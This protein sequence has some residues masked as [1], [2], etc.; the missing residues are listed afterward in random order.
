MHSNILLHVDNWNTK[1][2]IDQVILI[3][4][5]IAAEVSNDEQVREH[6]T[7]FTMQCFSKAVAE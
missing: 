4:L 5:T 2:F 6:G 3:D 1:E 7:V